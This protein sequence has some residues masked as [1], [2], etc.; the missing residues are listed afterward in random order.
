MVRMKLCLSLESL[1]DRS[2]E[3]VNGEFDEMRSSLH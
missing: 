3:L 1:R 2:L